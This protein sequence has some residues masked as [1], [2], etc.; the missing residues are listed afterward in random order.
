[1]QL[2][3]KLQSDIFNWYD[4]IGY[5]FLQLELAGLTINQIAAQNS[6]TVDY[7]ERHISKVKEFRNAMAIK[8][9]H[10]F[11][12]C[13]SKQK[14]VTPE[15]AKRTYLELFAFNGESSKK[16]YDLKSLK[17]RDL[18]DIFRTRKNDKRRAILRLAVKL[19]REASRSKHWL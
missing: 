9:D 5:K 3:L 14:N 16:K 2:L 7:A 10:Y 6:C 17:E 13:A 12:M 15:E 11:V 8:D 19:R 4:P 1:M 18:N